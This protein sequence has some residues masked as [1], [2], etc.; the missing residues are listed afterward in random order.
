MQLTILA[1][2]LL[3]VS[4]FVQPS[5]FT[6]SRNRLQASIDDEMAVPITI[7]G[8]NIALTEPL[9]DYINKKIARPLKKLRSHGSIMKCEVHLTVSKNPRIKDGH[10]VEVT[11]NLRGAMIRST[12]ATPDMY[13]SIDEVSDRLTR[14]LRKYKERRVQGYH[15]G[16][17]LEESEIAAFEDLAIENERL[18]YEEMEREGEILASGEPVDPASY[19]KLPKV[20]E[21]T[22]IKSFD[23]KKPTTLQEAIFALDYLD[24]DFYVFRDAESMEINVVYKRNAGGIGLIQPQ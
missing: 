22:K 12:M 11:T 7:T 18:A 6:T 24:H 5:T 9:K 16:Q 10:R 17:P 19:T 1:I 4:G 23:L 3:V 20:P 21:V 14:K 8:N 2:N 15:G 13:A